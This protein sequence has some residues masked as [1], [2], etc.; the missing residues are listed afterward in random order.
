MKRLLI[1]G[2]KARLKRMK[3]VKTQLG[4]SVLLLSVTPALALEDPANGQRLAEQ[5][6]ASCHIVTKDQSH[7][8]SA[9]PTFMTIAQRR[10]D[11]LDK[12]ESFLADPH[13]VM[14]NFSLTRQEIT[15]LVAY[16]RTLKP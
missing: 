14:P 5:W 15:D 13:P 6:C 4:A 3:F 8:V 12:L 1:K 7:A 2:G 9:T 10:G 16:I 11:E